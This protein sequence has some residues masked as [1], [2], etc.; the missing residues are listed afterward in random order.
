[1]AL[2]S[3][4]VE[5][6]WSG[7]KEIPRVRPLAEPEVDPE[8]VRRV[9]AFQLIG[10]CC[11]PRREGVE[12]SPFNGLERSLMRLILQHAGRGRVSRSCRTG[13]LFQ[14]TRHSLPS[15]GNGS[16]D[17]SARC[18][19]VQLVRLPSRMD[20]H[21]PSPFWWGLRLGMPRAARRKWPRN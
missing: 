21:F 13:F 17:F 14:R 6:L 16:V 9:W 3:R 19:L 18:C 7:E 2:G 15:S 4:R 10:Q 20:P 11:S 8:R 12:L 5:I 1:M